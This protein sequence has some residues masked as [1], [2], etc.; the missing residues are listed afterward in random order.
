M[1]SI[2]LLY[3]AASLRGNGFPCTVLFLPRL[4]GPLAS[5]EEMGCI[6]EFVR[7]QQPDLVGF[8]PMTCHVRRAEKITGHL[9][10]SP[11]PPY[12]VWGGIHPTLLPEECIRVA[13]A[14]CLGEGEDT[15]LE[16]VRRL[17]SGRDPTDVDNFWFRKGEEI[18]RNPQRRLR[19]DLDTLPFPFHDFQHSHVLHGGEIRPVDHTLF[20]KYMNWQ[21]EAHSIFATR[22]CP[23]GCS[24]C[25]NNALRK[26]Y[27][28][29]YVRRR[30]VHNVIEEMREAREIFPYTRSFNIQDD[31][32]LLN[33]DAW[34]EDF[35]RNYKKKIGLP[36]VCRVIPSLVNEKRITLLKEA[37]LQWAI[38]GLQS[39]S[40]RICR[41]I[42]K[43][44]T[45]NQEFLQC[46]RML[47]RH[48][49]FGIYDV[50]LDGPFDQEDDLLKTIDVLRQI[51]KPYALQVFSM[52]LLP[53]TRLKEICDEKGIQGNADPYERGF[54][55]IQETFLNRIVMIIPFSPDRVVV[56][57]LR[58]RKASWAEPLLQQYYQMY[59]KVF[60]TSR[61]YLS[62]FR[63]V[64]KV[65]KWA[66]RPFFRKN[67]GKQP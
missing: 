10:S 6:S 53:R 62:R 4:S 57:F 51:P 20:R 15:L 11:S 14:V 37:G 47:N 44:N 8:G 24:Y 22:G 39:G 38:A 60:V 58:H 29:K 42:Y 23:F 67:T 16:L 36:L 9:R 41:Q 33:D 43:R 34:L 17:E 7:N 40:E 61:Q 1:R 13:D 12:I 45:T 54:S 46:A 5:G 32:F 49:I 19:E 52:I 28:G 25:S 59:L 27:K 65:I 55:R 30:S 26:I 48:G 56:F 63:M 3:L 66:V 31:S 21:G 2:G 18:V 35:S 64:P 50:I